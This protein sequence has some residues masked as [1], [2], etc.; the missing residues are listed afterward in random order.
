M[1]EKS[2]KNIYYL[3]FPYVRKNHCDSC[4]K[5][6]KTSAHHLLP[7][8]LQSPN[9][10]LA[11][12]RIR[13]CKECNKQIHLENGELDENKILQKMNR[14]VRQ[15]QEQIKRLR[16]TDSIEFL[17]EMETR[18]E[19]ILKQ[20]KNLPNKV[21][22]KRKLHPTQKLFE[23]RLKE[24]KKVIQLYR[25]RLHNDLLKISRKT[26]RRENGKKK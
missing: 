10:P 7:V 14:R 9:K 18:H 13:V 6:R 16:D 22:D 26:K 11:K 8:R 19:Q 15:L 5:R 20:C 12:L 1:I 21:K 25:R 24:L 4:M 23:G 2:D 17:R 3:R